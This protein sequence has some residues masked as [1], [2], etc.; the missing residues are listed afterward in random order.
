MLWLGDVRASAEPTND[1]WFNAVPMRGAGGRISS[2]TAIQIANVYKCVRVVAETIGHL[3]LILYRRLP[4]G[5]KERAVT[6]PL[7]A[8]MAMRPNSLQT[9]MDWRMQMQAHIELRGN[10]YSRIEFRGASVANLWPLHPD[11]VK[12]EYLPDVRRLRYTVQE[13]GGKPEVLNQDEVLHLRSLAVDGYMGLNPVEA[14]RSALGLTWETEQFASR[15]Y[16]NDATPGGWIEHPTNF[17]DKE[18]REKFRQ[19]WREQQAGAN[20]GSTAVLEY[21]LKYHEVAMKLVDAQFMETRKYQATDVAGL[22]RVPPH[23]IGILDQAKF[24]NIEQQSID[25][26]TDGVLPRVRALEQRYSAELL[27]ESEQ[28]E[29]FFEFLLEGLLRGD[30]AAR[31]AF[32]KA[33]ITDGWMTR[34]EARESENRNPLPGL[35]TPL[36][37]LNMTDGT[38]GGAAPAKGARQ[39]SMERAAAEAFV[40]KEA[41]A[42]RALKLGDDV[43]ENASA[44]IAL[45]KAELMPFAARVFGVESRQLLDYEGEAVSAALSA[46]ADGTLK[47]SLASTREQ[48]IASLL[49]C[50]EESVLTMRCLDD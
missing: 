21:G 44:V 41:N 1:F 10:A 2:D 35:D 34:N 40:Q 29:Y 17:K 14:Q 20:R 47:S 48:R 16:K 30:A 6:H 49:M 12:V 18:A 8:V 45:Y 39:A 26:V 5:G 42:L 9:A 33:G 19:S 46:I 38:T 7:Y 28:R 27:S 31:A 3:P 37:P 32:Y 43:Q 4:G 50:L 22:W 24:A 13:R 23:K 36:Q 11:N 25:W 15:F